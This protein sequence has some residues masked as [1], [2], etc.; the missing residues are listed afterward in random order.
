VINVNVEGLKR[1]ISFAVFGLGMLGGLWGCVAYGRAM[2]VAGVNDSPPEILALTLAFASPLPACV[3]AL[4][5]R[6]AAG[7]WLIV[8]GCYLPVGMLLQRWFMIYVRHF[9]DQGTVWQTILGGL[10]YSSALI[11]LGVFGL[12]TGLLKWPKLL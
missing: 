4:W 6:I 11:A 1:T 8:S 12:V 3:L 7:I 9:P 10:P 5:K 2:F